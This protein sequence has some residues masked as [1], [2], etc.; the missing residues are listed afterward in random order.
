MR[1]VPPYTTLCRW[2][3]GCATTSTDRLT[4]SYDDFL[5]V[6]RCFLFVIPVDE[7]WYKAEYPAILE[8]LLQMPTET[9][10]SHFH[11]HGYFEGR[12]PFPPGKHDRTAPVPF[13][14]L[15]NRLRIV[16]TRGRLSVEIARDDLIALIKE[17]L[18]AVPVDAGWY[19][20]TYPDVAGTIDSGMLASA[21]DH[22]VE[23]GYFEN[24]IPFDI[25]VDADWY[26][27]RYD[28]VRI[29]LEHG[30][31][32]SAQDHFIRVGYKQGCRPTPP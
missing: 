12:N 9:A 6:L 14:K 21:A 7:D 10:A 18:R 19:R 15:Q 4:S 29:E 31:A 23:W 3:D 26:M 32:G 13:G 22:Y 24:R 1:Y 27:T 25:A 30:E 16:P 8:F 11:K 28:H 20:A 17:L 5:D 2:M